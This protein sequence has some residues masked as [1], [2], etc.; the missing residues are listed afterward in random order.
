[1][2]PAQTVWT[3]AITVYMAR[4]NATGSPASVWRTRFEAISDEQAPALNV[5][6]A[7]VRVSYE[8]AHDSASIEHESTVR[9]YVLA[10]DQVDV[11]ADPLIVWAWQQLGADPTMG[12][13]ITDSRIE[14]IQF[15][16]LDKSQSDKVCVDITICLNVEV[17]RGDPTINKTSGSAL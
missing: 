12:G 3:Q 6:A 2:L 17:G 15:G 10:T 4:L 7:E 5:F 14:K 11:A 8:G 9:G 13:I 1:M 16:Y